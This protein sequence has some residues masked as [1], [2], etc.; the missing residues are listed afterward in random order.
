VLR[1]CRAAVH[2]SLLALVMVIFLLPPYIYYLCREGTLVPC[3]LFSESLAKLAGAK[4]FYSTY[5]FSGLIK[6]VCTVCW[7]ISAQTISASTNCD[8][9]WKSH[10]MYSQVRIYAISQA[11]AGCGKGVSFHYY[12]DKILSRQN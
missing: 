2:L 5:E 11:L 3:F 4:P 9:A 10:E 7:R 8:L 6:T 12:V 1:R